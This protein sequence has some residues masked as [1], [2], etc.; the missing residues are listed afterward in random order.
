V[1]GRVVAEGC[2]VSAIP[3]GYRVPCANTAE[4]YGHTA[5]GYV[6]GCARCLD[7]SI[8]RILAALSEKDKRIEEYALDNQVLSDALGVSED[9]RF[10]LSRVVEAAKEDER[11]RGALADHREDHDCW[12]DCPAAADLVDDVARTS[13]VLHHALA[14]SEVKEGE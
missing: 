5:D 11:A 12:G 14:L 13:T 8:A 4:E 3:E 1:G 10:A 6:D 2:A 7:A 9:K